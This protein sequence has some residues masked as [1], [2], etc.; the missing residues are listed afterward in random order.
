MQERNC[1][2][3][4]TTTRPRVEHNHRRSRDVRHDG[5]LDADAHAAAE[6]LNHAQ[7]QQR[8]VAA[9]LQGQADAGADEQA[10][11]GHVDGPAAH[12]LRQLAGEGGRDALHDN[13]GRDS[14]VHQLQLRAE[15]VL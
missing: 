7:H 5:V 4:R 1:I 14:Q 15:L 13:V 11:R 9:A 10:E 12:A 2:V 3:V 6:A 8:R